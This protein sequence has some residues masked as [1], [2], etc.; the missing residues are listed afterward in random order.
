VNDEP[1]KKMTLEGQS[2]PSGGDGYIPGAW[3]EVRRAWADK[4]ISDEA[5]DVLHEAL[6]GP[7]PPAG[8]PLVAVPREQTLV[9]TRC[10]Q[11][12]EPRNGDYMTM[13]ETCDFEIADAMVTANKV[14]E[15]ALG[16]KDMTFAQF[17]QAMINEHPK[18]LTDKDINDI[19]HDLV[20]QDAEVPESARQAVDQ[21]VAWV[22]QQET[23]RYF[24]MTNPEDL[25][26][27]ATPPP[28][29]TMRGR[30]SNLLSRM[31]DA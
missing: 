23:S 14:L 7:R 19:F 15:G 22:D 9:C 27:P 29:P 16:R 28:A 1:K 21:A 18:Y 20:D 5:Y 10:K 2:D 11:P 24:K 17:R 3:D 31:R 25:F 30:L 8:V 6:F 12:F 13:C 4:H 26:G